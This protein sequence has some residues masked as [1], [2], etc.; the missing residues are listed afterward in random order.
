MYICQLTHQEQNIIKE[1]LTNKL[2]KEG[3]TP[4]EIKE[5]VSLA[6]CSRVVDLD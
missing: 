4:Q 5:A 2:H 6:M 1:N 3:Y